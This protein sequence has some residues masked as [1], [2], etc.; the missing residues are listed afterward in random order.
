MD[1][2][3]QVILVSNFLDLVQLRFNPIN[4]FFFIDQNMLQK[5][6]TRII[7]RLEA[8]LDAGS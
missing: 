2:L 6:A 1:L 4:M 7:A 8:A 5:L 3:R